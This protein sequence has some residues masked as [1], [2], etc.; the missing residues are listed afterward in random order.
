MHGSVFLEWEF[1]GL[2]AAALAMPIA[3]YV[4]LMRSRNASKA[5]V[6]VFG[7][8][9]I[10]TSAV[11]VVLLQD[12]S[13]MAATSSSTWDDRVFASSLSIA[14]YLVP[15]LFAGIGVNL[16]SHVLIAHLDEA[17]QRFGNRR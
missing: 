14:L 6:L 7:V 2:I 12:L 16:V 11:T 8:L 1:A 17:R 9:L 15:V 10:A 3:L 13:Q 5:L 4:Y